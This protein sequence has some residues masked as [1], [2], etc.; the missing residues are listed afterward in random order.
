MVSSPPPVLAQFQHTLFMTVL[1]ITDALYRWEWRGLQLRLK[2][3]RSQ[4]QV[5]FLLYALKWVFSAFWK[6]FW[7]FPLISGGEATLIYLL[8]SS[9]SFHRQVHFFLWHF[10]SANHKVQQFMFCCKCALVVVVLFWLLLLCIEKNVV[11]RLG[12]SEA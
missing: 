10:S 11:R 5:W 3:L 9:R 6:P 1:R 2:C 4:A 7:K 8:I 12:Y